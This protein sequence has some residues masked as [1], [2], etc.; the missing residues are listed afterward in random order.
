M[1]RALV[2]ALQGQA[3]HPWSINVAKDKLYAA[4]AQA[5]TDGAGQA[6]KLPS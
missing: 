1:I 6:R 2:W 4:T 3:E 5:N